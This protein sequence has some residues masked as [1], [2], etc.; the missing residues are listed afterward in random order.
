MLER[1]GS[2][3]IRC[4]ATVGGNIANASPV[5]DGP[6]AFMALAAELTLRKGGARRKML[7]E[8]F[9][10][11]YKKTAL[12]VGEFIESVFLPQPKPSSVYQIYKV[13]KR[14]EDDISRCYWRFMQHRRKAEK[15]ARFVSPR[16]YGGHTPASIKN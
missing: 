10:L 9:F 1:F 11:G 13:S 14:R 6:P 4:Q 12:R 7:L 2:P 16:W 5:A 8:N 15:S 3:Q